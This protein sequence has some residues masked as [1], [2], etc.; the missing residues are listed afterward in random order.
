MCKRY[1]YS[2]NT[3]NKIELPTFVKI[4]E[5]TTNK[6]HLTPLINTLANN[7]NNTN[8][9][10]MKVN[11]L[12][13]SSLQHNPEPTTQQYHND[14]DNNP[15]TENNPSNNNDRS[16]SNNKSNNQGRPVTLQLKVQLFAFNNV[17]EFL[18]YMKNITDYPTNNTYNN[19]TAAVN[20]NYYYFDTT[21]NADKEGNILVG[22]ASTANTMGTNNT[23]INKH[24]NVY[25]YRKD[26][27]ENVAD[28]IYYSINNTKLSLNKNINY[29]KNS[30][31]ITTMSKFESIVPKLIHCLVTSDTHTTVPLSFCSNNQFDLN[32]FKAKEFAFVRIHRKNKNSLIKMEII[33]FSSNLNSIEDIKKKICYPRYKN[34][35]KLFLVANINDPITIYCTLS[36]FQHKILWGQK[37]NNSINDKS[38]HLA[39]NNNNN[40]SS[41]SKKPKDKNTNYNKSITTTMDPITKSYRKRSSIVSDDDNDIWVLN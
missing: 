8:I 10:N 29:L 31:S 9:T 40:N 4:Q 1:S 22:D 34:N 30:L 26:S 3:N 32:P 33:P 12:T 37:Q 21:N 27:K 13:T 28:N 2:E 17:Y 25:C 7:S 39:N 38:F 14:I 23:H 15:K 19:S 11:I 36:G 18:I 35:M 5:L 6:S 16:N 24:I 41:N 20:N